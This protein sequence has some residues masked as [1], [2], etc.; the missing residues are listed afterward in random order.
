MT[1]TQNPKPTIVLLALP[2]TT[3]FKEYIVNYLNG[4]YPIFH[5]T[6]KSN[7]VNTIPIYVIITHGSQLE[8][9]YEKEYPLYYKTTECPMVLFITFAEEGDEVL[10]LEIDEKVVKFGT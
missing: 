1:N 6:F 7:D 3:Q 5:F 4:L 2:L 8:K 9:D 10:E